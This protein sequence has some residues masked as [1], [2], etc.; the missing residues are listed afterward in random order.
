M[1]NGVC[2]LMAATAAGLALNSLIWRGVIKLKLKNVK[3]YDVR[4]KM[5]N[6]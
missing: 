2:A 5:E 1:R 6:G 3:M 4:G